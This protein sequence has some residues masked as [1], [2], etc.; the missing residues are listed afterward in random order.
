MKPTNYVERKIIFLVGRY[1][2]NIISI[3]GIFTLGSGIIAGITSSKINPISFPEWNTE[4]ALKK[5]SGLYQD[6]L[7]NIKKQNDFSA[8]R[9]NMSI[10]MILVGFG[11]ISYSSV[12]S[13]ILAI[14]RNTRKKED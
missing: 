1:F 10:P 3:I 4:V 14:E 9:K 5:R 6:Y 13:A 8:A 11:A 2:W 7:D 12:F